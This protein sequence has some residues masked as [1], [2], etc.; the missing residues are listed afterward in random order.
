VVRTYQQMEMW[1]VGLFLFCIGLLVMYLSG[2]EVNAEKAKSMPR[3]KTAGQKN[4]IKIGPSKM[5]Q[6]SCIWEQH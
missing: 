6:I 5:W 2:L 3:S 1:E 4:S